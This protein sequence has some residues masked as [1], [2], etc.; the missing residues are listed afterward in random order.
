MMPCQPYA[1]PPH[2]RNAEAASPLS[3]LSQGSAADHLCRCA[4]E[5]VEGCVGDNREMLP[6]SGITY[7]YRA[8][9]DPSGGSEDAMTLAI[10]HKIKTPGPLCCPGRGL[11]DDNEALM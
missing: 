6:A 9:V 3:D 11:I 10:A 4:F 2:G 7:R 8:F 5:V 1:E